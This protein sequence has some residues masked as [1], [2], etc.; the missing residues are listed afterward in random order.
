MGT[1]S[2]ASKDITKKND[3]QNTSS[4]CDIKFLNSAKD[5]NN[6]NSYQGQSETTENTKITEKNDQIIQ[7]TFEW[8][9]GGNE[10]EIAGTFSDNWNKKNEM[11]KNLNTGIFEAT[12]EV[13]RG[14]HEF[15]F[16]V[17]KKWV[18]SQHYDRIKNKN[19]ISNNVIDLTNYIP[20]LVVN[21]NN[22]NISPSNKKKRKST[23]NTID[24]GCNYPKKSEVNLEAPILPQNFFPSF[25][26]DFQTKQE[27]LQKVFVKNIFFDR[28]K[29]L[30][31]NNT[32]KGILTISHEKLLHICH[33]VESNNDDD[34]YIRTSITQRNRH[35]FL[36]LVY[37]TPKK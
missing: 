16:I 24:Y 5:I 7:Y 36:T 12:L 28:T 17:D 21:N 22:A 27:F 31:E 32:F 13:P 23:K 14:R 6:K 35:K 34:K 8:K 25:N 2:S 37:F 1:I 4:E 33:N 10:V 26:L 15:K 29:N 9:D 18:C 20:P 19:N 11:K 3:S 30:V